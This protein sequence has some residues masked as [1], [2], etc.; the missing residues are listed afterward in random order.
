MKKTRLILFV[1]YLGIDANDDEWR[2]MKRRN[3]GGG[4]GGR[5]GSGATDQT[6]NPKGVSL[7]GLN[8]EAQRPQ[9]EGVKREIMESTLAESTKYDPTATP[10][11]DSK[12]AKVA[13]AKVPPRE[14]KEHPKIK[15]EKE[16]ITKISSE[17]KS[18]LM[19]SFTIYIFTNS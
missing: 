8:R 3:R 6:W 5:T 2:S 11:T 16:S 1:V 15:P 19:I 10:N 13:K 9:R 18:E 17:S 14:K 12:T 4:G 7:K